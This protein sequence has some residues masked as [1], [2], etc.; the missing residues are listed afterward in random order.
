MQNPDKKEVAEM[1]DKITKIRNHFKNTDK[2]A[3]MYFVSGIAAIVVFYMMSFYVYISNNL[4]D[5]NY[6]TFQDGEITVSI[7]TDK[8]QRN[9]FVCVDCESYDGDCVIQKRVV[10]MPGDEIK[11]D[12]G[13]LYINGKA[14]TLFPDADYTDQD[15]YVV[16]PEDEYFLMGDNRDVSLDSRYY[17]WFNKKSIISKT[18]FG[19]Y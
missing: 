2:N 17:G 4:G 1:K 10:G 13:T 16:V 19:I 11:I 8:I 6:P 12:K 9:D 15:M 5:S 7:R 14:D 18:L 3:M